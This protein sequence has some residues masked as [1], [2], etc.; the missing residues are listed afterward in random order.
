MICS[1]DLNLCA[2]TLLKKGPKAP[3]TQA[4]QTFTNPS[5]PT[6]WAPQRR[7]FL[8]FRRLWRHLTV[9]F[10]LS[11]VK[12][13]QRGWEVRPP[14]LTYVPEPQERVS[15]KALRIN[16]LL[17]QPSRHMLLYLFNH[18]CPWT[19]NNFNRA[20]THVKTHGVHLT[21]LC[22]ELSQ[23]LVLMYGCMAL[24]SSLGKLWSFPSG[25]G[26][27]SVITLHYNEVT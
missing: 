19:I 8:E 22:R 26:S 6:V 27:E 13:G 24:S 23:S 2:L 18:T 16:L 21:R 3:N 4:S 20:H 11:D 5:S 17:L 7:Y 14:A 15:E 10:Y 1:Q 9:W 25:E 12:S